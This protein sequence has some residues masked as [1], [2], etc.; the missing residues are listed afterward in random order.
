M[1]KPSR[2]FVIAPLFVVTASALVTGIITAALEG[3]ERPQ[4]LVTPET[5]GG[6]A[7]FLTHLSTDKP[8]YRPG[9]TVYLRGVVL[10]AHDRTPLPSGQAANATVEVIGPK[11]DVIA[12]GR[13]T[14]EDAVIGTS[15]PI[16]DQT[17]GGEYTV[18]VS[19]PWEGHAPA[20]RT[21]DIRAYRAPR[22]KT[23]VVFLRDGYGP[24]DEV[25][26][27]VEIERAEGGVPEAA[28][29]TA[30][31]RVDGEE[32][33]RGP[34][35]LNDRGRATA[36]FELPGEIDR[37]EGTLAF[38]IEDGGVVETA[39]KT[40]PILLQTLDIAFYPEGG[41][42]IAG[43]P[44]RV[45]VEAK[46]PWGDPADF[47]AEL[48][49]GDGEAVEAADDEPVTFATEH[50]GRGRFTFTP[51]ADGQ[52][53]IRIVKPSGIERTFDLPETKAAGV[54]LIINSGQDDAAVFEAGNAIEL[55]VHA[56]QPAPMGVT[57]SVKER[58]HAVAEVDFDEK[59]GVGGATMTLPDGV[60]GAVVATV[61]DA[62][63]Q[64]LAERLLF[65]RPTGGVVVQIDPDAEQY[66]PAGKA[67]ITVTTLDAETGDPV[68]AVVGLTVTDD[69]VLEMV[70]TREQA[71]RLPAMALLESE[72]AELR[73]A[74]VYLPPAA[75]NEAGPERSE[76]PDR[77]TTDGSASA[78]DTVDPDLA[79]DLL[80]GTQGWRKFAFVK[81]DEFVRDHGDAAKRVLA[82][83]IA[84]R[85][86]LRRERMGMMMAD[87]AEMLPMAAAMAAPDE[88]AAE[89]D[90]A[91]DPAA[92]DPEVVAEAGEV[93]A[94]DAEPADEPVAGRPAVD[95]EVQGQR[96]R[97][98]K[99]M[100]DDDFAGVKDRLVA[101]QLMV[102]QRQDFV[103]VRVYAHE[104]RLLH[105]PQLRTDFTETLFWADGIKT[106]ADGRATIEFAL[107]DAVTGFRVRADA[108]A[109]D[110]QLG[111]ASELIESVK[112]FYV[113][114]KL[115][116]ELT[117]GDRPL[118]PVVLANNTPS[119][120]TGVTFTWDYSDVI[121]AVPTL[122]AWDMSGVTLR[123]GERL[124]EEVEV[125]LGGFVG[126]ASLTFTGRS[127][128]GPDTVTRSFV[129]KP[130][131]FPQTI[132][133]GGVLEPGQ[134]VRHTITIPESRIAGSL[135]AASSVYPTPLANMTDAL[136]RLIREP[137][138]CFEQT[139]STTYPLVM[140]QQYFHTHA[141]VDPDLVTR[142]AEM[143]DK[144]YARLISFETENNGY[145]WF[146]STPPHEAL[147]AY[148]LLEFD[149]MAEVREVDQDM[150]ARTRGWLMDRRDGNG[151]F[152]LDSKAL[153][154]FGRAPQDT[155]DAY[156]VWA[157]LE[158]G[159]D[160]ADLKPEL[161]KVI[162]TALGSKDTYQQALAAL[163]AELAERSDDAAA[164]R[165][166]LAAAQAATGEV[167]GAATSIT[168][169]GGQGL[170]IEATSLAALAWLADDAFAPNVERAM[171]WL[172]EQCE[173]G[174]FGSTQ[175]TVLA[176][177]AIVAYD[178]AQA[179]PTA[180]GAVQIMVDGEVVADAVEFDEDTQQ[181]IALPDIAA[182]LTPGEHTI[183][184][185]MHNGS[186]MPYSVALNFNAVQP[187]SAEA[188]QLR[189]T[190]EL[191]DRKIAEGEIT[192]ARVTVK[193][194]GDD[195]VPT[196]VAIIG[197]P[198][199][200]EVRHDQLKELVEAETIAAYEVIGRD[201]V[202]YWRELAKGQ[203][204]ELPLSLTAAIPG[205]Y[206]GPASRA[207]LYYTD[208][209]KHWQPGL[210]VQIAPRR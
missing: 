51:E 5:L 197:I 30:I 92:A 205:T 126:E 163:S 80:L 156:A 74:Q 96:Q 100:A 90:A 3:P 45:Y 189:L 66:T 202:L 127:D 81:P 147:T 176:L 36:R 128:A 119:R 186:R 73:D 164:L 161:D 142:S 144:G 42:L 122:R 24:G 8:I 4:A 67:K 195:G 64:P 38:V 136:E 89:E 47:E 137:Y 200:L 174:R 39:S 187:A 169:S 157:L 82:V 78:R 13:A 149:D 112:P 194:I 129:V 190:T 54:N 23:Q 181:P 121:K 20:E 175:S 104:L 6:E 91:A 120:L 134:T 193:N 207:Y 106:N 130:K 76:G 12:G 61:W 84:P 152:K 56:A 168:R 2:L 85:P 117:Q 59:T 132:A 33:W 7:R 60:A 145:E 10:N 131:G 32:V 116:L 52:Y 108:F 133:L 150:I 182:A 19:Y 173:E 151:S 55:R 35:E 21:F 97:L 177:R 209:H 196:P 72:V 192:E 9:E 68:Q 171:G 88:P 18:K 26:A 135:A 139:S 29:V 14:A 58:V 94:D 178:K 160:P 166:K 25:T 16:P 87:G 62:K 170:V 210:S 111:H 98:E 49:N 46:T 48:V 198:G 184:L 34:A 101:D 125:D 86:A 1:N 206:T 123:E 27:S 172:F 40:I 204:V 28:K 99:V 11:G 41:E 146:G 43:V 141:D 158:S 203:T 105:N 110:G 71:P 37:G 17:P 118:V 188:C 65:V 63:G 208:E 138:G 95:A 148:G 50:E 180:P 107:S 162:K 140:A 31:A 83:R 113:E 159:S 109:A 124:R 191:A 57:L 155:T 183:E 154:S 103:A 15:W 199:G 44:N 77:A 153:D 114:P 102:P 79:L 201:V 167:T 185:K 115:P 70:E 143:L 165:Q 179:R 93:A 75:L 53:A 22:L 69:S